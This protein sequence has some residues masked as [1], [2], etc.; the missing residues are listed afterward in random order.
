VKIGN[1]GRGVSGI[2]Q[3]NQ[4]ITAFNTSVAGH[5]TPEGQALIAA[6]IFTEAQL[7]ALKAVIPTI[8]L[9]PENNPNPF[10]SNPFDVTMRITRPIKLENAYV[11]HNL[12]I[13][14]YVDIFN[15]FNYRGHGAYSGLGAGFLSL[16]F[17]YAGAGRGQELANARAFAFGPR[18]IQLGFRVSF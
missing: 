1:W 3:L 16:N 13:E 5:P 12:Q 17:D 7:K 18:I 2:K 14:P 6:G 11:V 9:V 15:L 8:P 10:A 4:L